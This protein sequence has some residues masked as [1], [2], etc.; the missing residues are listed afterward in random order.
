MEFVNPNSRIMRIRDIHIA[1]GLLL[2]DAQEIDAVYAATFDLSETLVEKH[3]RELRENHLVS[4]K[5][6]LMGKPEEP[7]ADWEKELI[8]IS[9]PR[10][11]LYAIDATLIFREEQEDGRVISWQGSVPTFFL[12]G[13]ALGIT[14]YLHAEQY[15]IDLLSSTQPDKFD[16]RLQYVSVSTSVRYY[17]EV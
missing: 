1:K 5:E 12:N 8:A 14:D 16:E 4:L 7:L 9:K 17:E 6:N 15:A 10:I 11:T 13:E 2:V 3:E